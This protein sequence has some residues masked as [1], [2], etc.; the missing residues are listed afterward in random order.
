MT[1]SIS[2]MSLLQLPVEELSEGEIECA[3][4]TRGVN[5]VALKRYFRKEAARAATPKS[6]PPVKPAPAVFIGLGGWGVA[7]SNHL[8]NLLSVYERPLREVY[9]LLIDANFLCDELRVQKK[10]GASTQELA[11]YLHLSIDAV[12][13]CVDRLGSSP[14]AAFDHVWPSF[15]S[16]PRLAA[17]IADDGALTGAFIDAYARLGSAAESRTRCGFAWCLDLLLRG[18]PNNARFGAR[19]ATRLLER[20]VAPDAAAVLYMMFDLRPSARR[21]MPHTPMDAV[22]P[23]AAAAWKSFVRE[24]RAVAM[25]AS[26]IVRR[27]KTRRLTA[28]DVLGPRF[29]D[30]FDA[31]RD[32][33]P[34]HAM[35]GMGASK[36]ALT[37]IGTALRVLPESSREMITAEICTRFFEGIGAG[38]GHSAFL[39]IEALEGLREA[40][41]VECAKV[42]PT[43]AGENIIPYPSHQPPVL[44]RTEAGSAP[45]DAR[46]LDDAFWDTNMPRLLAYA[47]SAVQAAKWRGARG[48]LPAGA[49][50]PSDYVLEAVTLVLRGDRQCPANLSPVR[51]ILVVIG[52]LIRRDHRDR[53][54]QTSHEFITVIPRSDGSAGSWE[55]RM[56]CKPLVASADEMLAARELVQDFKEML[57]DEY[58]DYV[59]VLAG[60]AYP[61]RRERADALDLSESEIRSRD[62]KIRKLRALWKGSSP[63]RMLARPARVK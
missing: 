56:T 63:P 29:A 35:F 26:L 24:A 54:N 7:A 14:S 13:R 45:C 20:G 27:R 28:S 18:Q 44:I 38:Q 55:K 53:E 16:L 22:V 40:L 41:P 62:K 48:E 1:E 49:C 33:V 32:D 21:W 36:L 37:L 39:S 11:R 60:D 3:L 31:M 12:G 9:F 23:T 61:T 8:R 52:T 57:P 59:D 2:D 58:R 4:T 42:M 10:R 17:E 19:V 30:L 43:F 34:L 50:S 6:T 5:V 47:R 46:L 15:A 51:F 25:D